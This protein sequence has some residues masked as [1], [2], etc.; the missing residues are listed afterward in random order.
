[1]LFDSY[2][3]IF[4]FLPITLIGYFTLNH[5]KLNT[6]AKIWL[7]ICS[8]FFYAYN[9]VSFLWLIIASMV[10]NYAV[11]FAFHKIDEKKKGLRL[12]LFILG[13]SLNIGALF[14]YK[15]LNFVLE[16]ANNLFNTDFV[17][18]NIVLP[19]GI[20]FFTFQQIAYL[21]DSFNGKA[22]LYS[23]IDYAL[24]VT[25]FPQ[26]IEGPIVLHH[27]IIPQFRDESKQRFN[28]DNLVKGIYAFTLGSVKKVLIADNL[29]IIASFGN[30]NIAT[31]SSFEAVLTILSFTLQLYF[32]F[33]GYCDM[34][35]GISY[36]FNIELPINFNSP[37]KARNISDFWKRWHMTLTGFMSNYIYIPLGGSRRGTLRTCLNIMIVFLVS[38]I[39]HGADFTFIVWGL[40]HGVAMV[41]YR[42]LKKRIDKIPYAITWALTF[43]F[44]NLTWVYFHAASISDANLLISR[45]FSGGFTLQ[46]ELIEALKRMIPVSVVMNVFGFNWS[47]MIMIV[48]FFAGCIAVCLFAKN[49]QEKTKLF[50]PKVT[51]LLT[52][53]VLLLLVILSLSG[54][55]TFLYVNF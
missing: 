28:F 21:V 27:E 54:V 29:G 24:F 32:D 15:D 26:L 30:S 36:M 22:P 10:V 34:A 53:F 39:W 51:N 47:L 16:T 3:F 7:I 9:N 11:C 5:F 4:A 41:F 55:S 2:I 1:M 40:M 25:F 8:L 38:G 35:I 18:L 6:V 12:F 33:S 13:L 17:T 14:F 49:V 37:Y 23:V 31:L 45:V 43:V 44:I 50:R 20:S 48:A 19:L 46:P 42:L 52:T